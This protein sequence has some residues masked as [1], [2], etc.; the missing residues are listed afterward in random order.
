MTVDA[1][2]IT[3]RHGLL[4]EGELH[5][6]LRDTRTGDAGHDLLLHAGDLIVLVVGVVDLI[7]AALSVARLKG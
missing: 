4:E 5:F 3:V 1:R 2:A 7:L 6:D